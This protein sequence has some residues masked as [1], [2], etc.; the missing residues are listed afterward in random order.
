MGENGAS[1][2]YGW[3]RDQV[4]RTT[5]WRDGDCVRP[6]TNL[7]RCIEAAA[8]SYVG[9]FQR[10]VTAAD[11]SRATGLSESLLNKWRYTPTLPKPAQIAA[12]RDSLGVTYLSVLEAALT[13]RGW[14]PEPGRAAG[15]R[16]KPAV[17]S[18][19]REV[20]EEMDR[21]EREQAAQQ[22]RRANEVG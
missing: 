10:R 11:I 5:L 22:A 20:R 3:F 7:W 9:A 6:E 17:A 4:R 13:D 2:L 15:P 1:W 12:V 16:F 14:L 8:Q 21:E 19:L 18:E